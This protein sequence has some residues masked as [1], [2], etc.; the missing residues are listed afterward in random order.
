MSK[1]IKMQFTC[2]SC[3]SIFSKWAGQCVHCHEYNTIVQ[4]TVA[5]AQPAL[6][7]YTGEV[8]EVIAYNQIQAESVAR[9]S[10]GNS[11]LDRALGGGFVP[12]ALCVLSG[13]PGVGKSTL[14]LQMMGALS[15]T[16]KCLYLSGE[17]SLGQIKLRGD[18]MKISQ[19]SFLLAA[20]TE[21]ELILSL[22]AQH[23]PDVIVIDSIQTLHSQYVDQIPGSVNQIRHCAHAL[24]RYAKQ[25]HATVVIIGH[26]NKE[27]VL[28]GPKV[29]EHMVDTVL[30]LE[31]DDQGRYRLLRTIKNRFG[32]VNELGILCMTQEGLKSVLHPSALF[33]NWQAK[34]TPG[35]AVTA[36]WEGSRVLLA[37]IQALVVDSPQYQARRL[38]VG[39]DGSRLNMLLAVLSRLRDWP[40]SR[41]D[42]FLNVVGGLKIQETSADCALL[43]AVFSS[44]KNF[45]I[46]RDVVI[47]GEIGLGGEL[48]PVQYA[49][50][51]VKEALKHGYKKILLPKANSA[52]LSQ[53]NQIFYLETVADLLEL[54]PN[55]ESIEEE[56]IS[57]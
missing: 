36:L 46:P 34:P 52:G 11:E 38:V 9:F 3:G 30:H 7:H 41:F 39:F 44:V 17:E 33:T 29:F 23:R 54:L 42:V 12:G 2:Q 40:G 31:S 32:P 35:T 25:N 15:S 22:L 43:A 49:P 48:R 27:G 50:E 51:R 18:R 20:Q 47:F 1:K 14:T 19:A 37:E 28:A 6:G 57:S 55:L 8:A 53:Y 45:I 13:D 24:T 56:E 16:K 5:P 4:E 21:L 26:V 10:S